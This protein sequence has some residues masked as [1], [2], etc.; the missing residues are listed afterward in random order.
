MALHE[1]GTNAVKYGALSTQEGRI[2][3]HWTLSDD[4]LHLDWR[5]YDG[6]P[7]STPERRGF[8]IKM[9]ERALAS[10]LGARVSVEFASDGVH[11]S[12]DAPRKGNVT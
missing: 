4:R 11:C 1:L 8:G 7:V 3:I 12:I 9:I 5:E 10:D 2:E 6:P